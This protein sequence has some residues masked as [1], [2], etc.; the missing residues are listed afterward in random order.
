MYDAQLPPVR[1]PRELKDQLQAIAD[2]DERTLTYVI[3][4]ACQEYI[5]RHQEAT[6]GR[7]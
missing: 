6:D 5:A 4:K 3:K 2:Q 7:S 1:C